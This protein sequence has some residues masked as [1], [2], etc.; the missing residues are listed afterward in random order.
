[1]RVIVEGRGVGVL[2]GWGGGGA[3]GDELRWKNSWKVAGLRVGQK[4][5]VLEVE[6]VEQPRA[7]MTAG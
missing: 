6:L 2:A 4:A 5:Q 7:G 3:L 1:M